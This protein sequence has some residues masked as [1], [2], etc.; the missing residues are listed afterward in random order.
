MYS[1]LRNYMSEFSLNELKYFLGENLCKML[2]EW[3]KDYENLFTKSKLTNMIVKVHGINILKNKKFRKTLLYKFKEEEILSF[4]DFLGPEFKFETSLE[5]I[6]NNIVRKKWGDNNISI[7]YL[8]IL[9]INGSVFLNSSNVTESFYD[10][11][12]YDCFYELLDYQFVLKQKCLNLLSSKINIPRL[13]IHMPTGTGKTKTAM[14]TIIQHY[15]ITLKKNGLII[16]MAHTVEL[17]DQALETFNS[18]W[19]HLGHGKVKIYKLFGNNNLH[20]KNTDD[21]NGFMICSFQKLISIKQNKNEL[22]NSLCNHCRLIVV[23]EAHKAVAEKTKDVIDE[24]MRKKKNMKN[25]CLIGLTATPGRNMFEDI[26]N[27][28]LVR[29]F[30]NRIFTIDTKTLDIINLNHN[31]NYKKITE[32]DIICYLQERGILAK[33]IRNELSYEKNLSENEIK[34]LKI[35]ATANG[36]KDYSEKFLKQ[37]GRNKNRNMAILNKLIELD[38]KNSPTILFACSVEHGKLLSSALSLRGVDNACVFGEMD[39]YSRKNAITRF[40]NINDKMNILINYGV[41]TTGFD[42]TNIKCVFITRPTQSIVL[43]SQMLGRGL[44]GPKMGGNKECLLIDIKDNLEN[45]SNESMAFKFFN[46]YW[47]I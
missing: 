28:R 33:I 29:M 18:V 21:L 24:L 17:I 5:K 11:V 20:I 46:N 35:Q 37:I 22:F 25:R 14:H 31:E 13:L 43:Y 27:N 45:Y 4:R 34:L 47:N 39:N 44:R 42:A 41:L 12:S 1:K 26:D 32:Q 38:K 19:K 36:Y 6:I 40:K 16:W 9:D 2:M 3:A 30:E 23:D 7:H 8:S 15:N 10:V